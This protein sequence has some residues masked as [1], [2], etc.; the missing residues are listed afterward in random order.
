MTNMRN[1][2]FQSKSKAFLTEA[3][4]DAWML[5]LLHRKS[6]IV[7]MRLLRVTR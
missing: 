5:S 1:D 4:L 7:F 6:D 2:T 3:D